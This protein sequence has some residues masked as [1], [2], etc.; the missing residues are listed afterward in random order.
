MS[1]VEH[2]GTVPFTCTYLKQAVS[3][4]TEKDPLPLPVDDAGCVLR[5]KQGGEVEQCHVVLSSVILFKLHVAQSSV[6]GIRRRLDG[7]VLK[8]SPVDVVSS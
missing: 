7:V 1:M 5:G 8:S 4:N 6:C 3:S 2:R